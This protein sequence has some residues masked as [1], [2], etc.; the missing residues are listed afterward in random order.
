M[1]QL[2]LVNSLHTVFNDIHDPSAI[3][4]S[5]VAIIF[6]EMYVPVEVSS[7]AG[8]FD[9]LGKAFLGERC[10]PPIKILILTLQSP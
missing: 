6:Q 8:N 2:Q 5:L 7:P 4:F 10:S 3:H 9:T 1:R